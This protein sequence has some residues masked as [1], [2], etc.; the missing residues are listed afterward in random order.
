MAYK[1][2]HNDPTLPQQHFSDKLI[3]KYPNVFLHT[4]HELLAS[5]THLQIVS[6]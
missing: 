2:V 4:S 6:M 5:F 3:F 1:L